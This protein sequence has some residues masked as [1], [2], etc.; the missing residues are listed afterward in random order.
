M[1]WCLFFW[2]FLCHKQCLLIEE[3]K[4]TNWYKI[5]FLFLIILWVEL[6][7]KYLWVGRGPM[8]EM[9]GCLHMN[10]SLGILFSGQS[11]LLCVSC[12]GSEKTWLRRSLVDEFFTCLRIHIFSRFSHRP[13]RS[14][15]FKESVCVP[16]E[17]LGIIV[18]AAS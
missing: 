5:F 17:D 6:N 7:Q 16:M 13:D 9:G 12:R 11:S 4:T 15:F 8:R 14:P 1:R 3:T 2:V 10:C 18:R